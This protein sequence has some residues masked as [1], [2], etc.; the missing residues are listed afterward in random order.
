MQLLEQATFEELLGAVDMLCIPSS[1]EMM[2]SLYKDVLTMMVPS[3]MLPPVDELCFQKSSGI[4]LYGQWLGKR[5]KLLICYDNEHLTEAT[6]YSVCK[7]ISIRAKTENAGRTGLMLHHLSEPQIV[8]SALTG[9]T[10]G[11]YNIGLYKSNEENHADANP[12]VLYTYLSPGVNISDA[13]AGI[14]IGLVQREV[15]DLVNTPANHKS[16]SLLG[17]WAMKNASAYG[18][19]AMVLDKRQL[20]NLGMHA[21]LAVNR[22]SEDPAVLI[23]THYKHPEANKKIVLIGKGV[24][25]DTGGISIKD[26]KNMHYMKSDMAGA[27]AALGTVEAC[28]RLEMKVDVM[29]ITPVTDNS[30]GTTA[31]KPGDVI[32]SFA[33]KSIE[34]ID[35]DAEGRLILADAL[36]YAVKEYQP[37]V[38]IDMA[39]LTGS[40]IAAIG[41]H[42]AGLFTKNDQLAESLTKAGEI[43][44]ERLW[45]MPMFDEY[46]ED[47]QSDIAD[48]KNLSDK[49]YAGSVT[50]AKFLEF[51][52][53][54]HP[55][56][57]HLDIAGMGFQPNGFGKGYCATAYGVRL[58]VR[59]MGK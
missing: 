58:L 50:A 30:I 38:M 18:Y 16:P 14:T 46:Q 25:F 1:K 36:A 59:W 56:W 48:I 55:V 27:A 17:E 42:A 15:M 35:T 39:T 41:P 32:S 26:S 12:A 20:T 33:G 37:D 45:R 2:D 44:G 29:A 7:K 21:L 9:W 24:I 5:I 28:A 8:Q 19:Q 31:L 10:S 52:T 23:V 3:E 49:P 22:G 51:F 4:I 54:A 53:S 40:I 11:L 47:M 57:A 6:A 13:N 34:V 43:S